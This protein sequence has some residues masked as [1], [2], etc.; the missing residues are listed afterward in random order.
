MNIDFFMKKAINQAKLAF[1]ENEV[2]VGGV[3]VDNE[4]NVIISKAFNKINQMK[5]PILHCEISLI[6]E[7]CKKTK[8]KYLNHTTLFVTLEPCVMCAAAISESHI[9]KVYFGAYDQ[10]KGG[11]EK[12]QL[13]YKRENIFQPE[14]YGGILED[15]SNKL[16][17]R[18]FSKIRK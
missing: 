1:D 6:I 17:K 4:T 14:I 7:G 16:L 13:A 10:K 15:E 18:F 8:S 11:I 3:L 5:N 9:S 12:F 2:P